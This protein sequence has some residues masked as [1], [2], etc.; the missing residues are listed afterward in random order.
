MPPPAWLRHGKWQG[1][2]RPGRIRT[3]PSYLW[4]L[5][6]TRRCP[7]PDAGPKGPQYRQ[8]AARS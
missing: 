2:C 8:Q 1:D 6:R 4:P 5:S 7:C 3:G